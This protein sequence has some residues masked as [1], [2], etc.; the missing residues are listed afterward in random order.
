MKKQRRTIGAVV[1]I[2]LDD[3]THCYGIVL[4]DASVGVF[5]V[6]T[7]EN[8]E[9]P[10]ILNKE[11][12][13]IVAVYNEAITSGRWKK[14]GKVQLDGRFE[15]LPLKFIQDS[16]DATSIDIYNPNTG[17]I[18]PSTK[19]E[20]MGLECAAVWAAEHV[21]SRIID[22]FNNKENVWVKQLALK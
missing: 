11:V 2:P 10:D 20:C 16:H 15:V 22:Y 9:I 1:E 17:E 12:L 4:E 19:E 6:K 18:T 5:K 13:F 8:L 7:N 14:V 3:G 21:E